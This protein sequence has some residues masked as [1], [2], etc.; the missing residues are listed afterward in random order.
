MGN[1]FEL[2]HNHHERSVF[3]AVVQLAPRYPKLA[4]PSLLADVACVALNRLPP[5]YIR[6]EVD[7]T[8]YLSDRERADNQA[9]V[10]EAVNSAFAFV[11]ARLDDKGR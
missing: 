8:F 4:A 7:F 11:L 10:D 6:H 5:R 3:A 9:A 1:E 2:V